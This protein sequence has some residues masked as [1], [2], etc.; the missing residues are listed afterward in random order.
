MEFVCLANRHLSFN[1][2]ETCTR[3]EKYKQIK[4]NVINNIINGNEMHL[5]QKDQP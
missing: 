5:L 3:N 4:Q 1:V 2:K